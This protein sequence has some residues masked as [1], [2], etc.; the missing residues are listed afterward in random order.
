MS[1]VGIKSTHKRG[2][3]THNFQHRMHVLQY[4]LGVAY[5]DFEITLLRIRNTYFVFFLC[6]FKAVVR[7]LLS[8]CPHNALH[9]H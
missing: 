6:I 2:N 3:A 1:S 8:I 7:W 9:F 5:S 4:Y